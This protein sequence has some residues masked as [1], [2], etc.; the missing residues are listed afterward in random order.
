MIIALYFSFLVH[1]S[2]SQTL[3]LSSSPEVSEQNGSV[4]CSVLCTLFWDNGTNCHYYDYI[5]FLDIA[6]YIIVAGASSGGG[7]C[8]GAGPAFTLTDSP[9]PLAKLLGDTSLHYFLI[10]N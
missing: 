5:V 3:S 6:Y 9:P 1:T 2:L 4:K 7:G 10:S 8:R